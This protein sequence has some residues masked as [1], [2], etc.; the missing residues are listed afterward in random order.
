MYSI[1]KFQ[2]EKVSQHVWGMALVEVGVSALIKVN[3]DEEK[4]I[5]LVKDF[6]R[7]AK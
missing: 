6:I 3:E 5:D 2:N 1:L 7:R 4:I